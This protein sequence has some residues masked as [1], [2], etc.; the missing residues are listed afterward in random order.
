MYLNLRV[1]LTPAQ[2]AQKIA[3]GREWSRKAEHYESLGFFGRARFYCHLGIDALGGNVFLPPDM[4]KEYI[5]LLEQ[6][7][8]RRG[9]LIRKR[10]RYAASAPEAFV[11][12]YL[13]PDPE[14]D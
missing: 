8:L 7:C 6:L 9:R 1:S 14:F 10:Q 11:R 13:D 12:V 3:E 4:Y 2:T 5:E